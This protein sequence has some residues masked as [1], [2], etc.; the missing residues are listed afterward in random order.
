MLKYVV[1]YVHAGAIE[2]VPSFW[3]V[4]G[5]NKCLRDYLLSIQPNAYDI[6]QPAFIAIFPTSLHIL[7]IYLK[8]LFDMVGEPEM[9]TISFFEDTLHIYNLF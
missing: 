3:S 6:R 8:Y 4:F 9:K 5:W 7:H 2:F 1:E